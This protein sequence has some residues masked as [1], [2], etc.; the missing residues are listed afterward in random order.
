MSEEIIGIFRMMNVFTP[1]FPLPMGA[2]EAD[3]H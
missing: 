2:D 3:V 1:E